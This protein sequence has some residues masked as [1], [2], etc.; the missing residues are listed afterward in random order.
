MKLIA[1]AK[2]G[3]L[4]AIDTKNSSLLLAI[5]NDRKNKEEQKLKKAK[6]ERMALIEE[7][8][9]VAKAEADR[10]GSKTGLSL[11]TAKGVGSSLLGMGKAVLRMP[12][13]VP[14]KVTQTLLEG[15]T[16]K[17]Q[18]Y[19]PQTGV[20]KFFY[21]SEP[22]QSYT[23]DQESIQKFAQEKGFGRG[24]SMALGA[25]GA[26]AEAIT[27]VGLPGV[28]K[29]LGNTF[30]GKA[31]FKLTGKVSKEVSAI[32]VHETVV[33]VE[34][35]VGR[36]LKPDEKTAVIDSLSKGISKEDIVST[37]D[38]AAKDPVKTLKDFENKVVEEQ[39]AISKDS[40]DANQV[41]Q[42][43]E[44]SF[45]KKPESKLD[46]PNR[47][48]GEGLSYKEAET[49][50][51]AGGE[52]VKGRII[53]ATD[54]AGK[55]NLEDG[56]HLLEAY[57]EKGIPVPKDKVQFVD[58]NA[59]KVF[60]DSI[61]EQVPKTKSESPILKEVNKQLDEASQLDPNIDK[62]TFSKQFSLAEKKIAKDPAQ[63]YNDALSRSEG[64][65][66]KSSLQ[67]MLLRNA[68][69]KGDDKAIA[70]LGTAAAITGRKAGQTSVMFRALYDK[71]P[72]SRILMNLARTKLANVEAR[73][74]KSM[75]KI[76]SEGS[77]IVEK[78]TKSVKKKSQVSLGDA[79]SIIDS[80]ICK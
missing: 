32:D 64:E 63:A 62:T 25:V 71:D 6:E 58:E 68:I 72:M 48:Q 59:R 5:E 76:L 46:K 45:L 35:L 57:R 50:L 56:R 52:N 77:D 40:Y 49:G 26:G 27:D 9:R 18:T 41:S 55:V 8:A 80:F 69:E 73:F 42:V 17:K 16:G 37:L 30:I 1:G 23:S 10:L 24:A 22:V 29:V 31:L 2:Q 75:K 61:K 47:L 20:E 66:T 60:T 79:Q 38:E 65:M 53:L 44:N 34:K 7:N 36:Q 15:V 43:A 19:T 3:K 33:E 74:P 54:D 12:L 39:K 14:M 78:V 70:E 28:G 4:R 11:E 13:T 51:T 67:L 21:G